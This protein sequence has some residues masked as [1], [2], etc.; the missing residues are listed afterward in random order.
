MT[1]DSHVFS[2][3][4]WNPN[5][6]FILIREASGAGVIDSWGVRS[7][8]IIQIDKRD[9]VTTEV[10]AFLH[11][12]F[13]DGKDAAAFADSCVAGDG[14]GA[15]R[16]VYTSCCVWIPA[17]D[18]SSFSQAETGRMLKLFELEH[19]SL[20]VYCLAWSGFCIL[21]LFSLS[22]CCCILISHWWVLSCLD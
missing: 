4:V 13:R 11:S 7:E 6:I 16:P 15:P 22:E 12:C 21:P 17:A 14:D 19:L 18:K 9:F 5:F 8:D 10:W 20:Q 3:A 1:D 2:R